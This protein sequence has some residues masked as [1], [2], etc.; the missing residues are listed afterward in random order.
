MAGAIEVHLF[1]YYIVV[2]VSI[3]RFRASGGGRK[4]L[5]LLRQRVSQE[6]LFFTFR[7]ALAM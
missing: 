4:Q 2:F 6:Q 1:G 5:S 7:K 3:V